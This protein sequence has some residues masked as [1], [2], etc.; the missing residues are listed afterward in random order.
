MKE[1][2]PHGILCAKVYRSMT[3]GR[4]WTTYPRRY[5]R[6]LVLKPAI[7]LEKSWGDYRRTTRDHNAY[8]AYWTAATSNH[9]VEATI[10]LTVGTVQYVDGPK[11]GRHHGAAKVH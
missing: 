6:K 10:S 5:D 4:R 3:S 9:H 2:Y 11:E 7:S 8:L 1:K